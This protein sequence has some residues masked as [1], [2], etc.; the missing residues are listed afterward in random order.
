VSSV[1]GA[2]RKGWR[3]PATAWAL[4]LLAVAGLAAMAWIDRLLRQA[5]RLDLALLRTSDTAP[6]VLAIVSAATVGAVLA[7]RRP[8]HPVGW[9][10]LALALS[11]VLSG[12]ATGYAN[13]GLLAWPGTLP[14]AA[15][16]AIY[17]GV[18]P[19]PAATCVS[20]VLL[21]TPTGSLPSSRWRWLA[22]VAV[23]APV[24]G[25]RPRHSGRSTRR[26][27]PCTTR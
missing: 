11:V 13:Y 26:T 12:V 24:V 25:W 18:A 1:A 21:L 19:L 7:S 8:C 6:Y 17:N 5:G 15:W 4:W 10:L 16:P 23:V 14:G 3:A 22:R 2:G 27:N 9:L 20:F